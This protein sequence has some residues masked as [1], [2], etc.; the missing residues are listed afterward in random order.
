VKCVV[1][2]DGELQGSDTWQ[3]DSVSAVCSTP[4]VWV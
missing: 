1:R 2:L 4:F 3:K